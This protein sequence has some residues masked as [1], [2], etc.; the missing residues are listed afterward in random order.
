MDV[1]VVDRNAFDRETG[2]SSGCSFLQTSFW[3]RFKSFAGWKPHFLSV[4]MGKTRFPLVVLQ[5]SIGRVFTFAY[6]PDGPAVDV[7]EPSRSALLAEL[8]SSL[9]SV[10]GANCLFVRF[11][12]PWTVGDAAEGNGIPGESRG[13]GPASQSAIP[14]GTGRPGFAPPLRKAVA[15]VQPPDTV[16]LDLRSPGEELLARMKPKWR[17]NIRLAAKRGITVSS[18][19]ADADG[20]AIDSAVAGFHALY[21]ATAERD[22]IAIHPE[23]YYRRLVACAREELLQASR[24]G[25]EASAPGQA[26][27]SRGVPDLRFWFAH[28]GT[29]TIAGIVTLFMG[30][31]AVYLYGASADRHRELMPAYALQWEA[32]RAAR[33]AG[34]GT[35]DFY[36]IPPTQDPGHPMAGLYR[37]KTGFGGTVVHRAGSWD[38]VYRPL[39][40]SLFSCIESARA[41]WYKRVRKLGKRGAASG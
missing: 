27:D 35:Y 21:R 8:G 41:F 33:E 34:C 20:Q 25:G 22:R 26:A 14:V 40:A 3:A 24:P 13:D 38:Y 10:L 19:R 18:V 17:Y 4:G 9:R 28:S 36:G 11:D 23:S 29:D 31:R 39:P 2:A 15:D 6:V 16:L 5:R 7:P 30:G 12:P 32:I 1:E 37:F